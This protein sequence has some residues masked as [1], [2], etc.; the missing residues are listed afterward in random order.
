MFTSDHELTIRKA[1]AEKLASVPEVGFILPTP[2]FFVD[3][4][5]FWAGVNS[6]AVNTKDSIDRANIAFC[7]ISLLKR[8]DSAKE[9]CGD[10][11]FVRLTYNF[12]F[13]RGYSNERSD[14]SYTPDAFLKATLKTYNQ[15]VKAVLDAW[16]GFLGNQNI[17]EL[18]DGIEGNTTSLTQAEFVEEKTPCRYIPGVNGHQVNLQE[19]VEVL[20]QEEY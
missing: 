17:F 10:N 9:G 18:P 6:L 1:L 2:I 14:E 5:D 19:I 8:V 15:F 11:P 12:H 20:I 4:A 7:A 3:S 13:F 16:T